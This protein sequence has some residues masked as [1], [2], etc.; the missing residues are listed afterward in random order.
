MPS[1]ITLHAASKGA[2]TFF[3]RPAPMSNRVEDDAVPAQQVE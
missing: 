3:A 2:A 1:P